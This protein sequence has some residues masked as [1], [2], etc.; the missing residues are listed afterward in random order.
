MLGPTAQPLLLSIL[1]AIAKTIIFESVSSIADCVLVLVES[2][3]VNAH[4]QANLD[5]EVCVP[6]APD[7]DTIHVRL[8]SVISKSTPEHVNSLSSGSLHSASEVVAIDSIVG[9]NVHGGLDVC[10]Q[11]AAPAKVR[12]R[13]SRF[14]IPKRFARH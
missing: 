12:P 4:S 10:V 9:A 8:D 1:S 5:S 13:I 3:L 11:R 7:A 2:D 6:I 14:C